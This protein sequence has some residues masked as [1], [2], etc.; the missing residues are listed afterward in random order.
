V[1]ADLAEAELPEA[2]LAEEAELSEAA[3]VEAADLFADVVVEVDRFGDGPAARVALAREGARSGLAA[4]P[5]GSLPDAGRR[6]GPGRGARAGWVGDGWVR[7]LPGDHFWLGERPGS[8]VVVDSRQVD[9]RQVERPPGAP[10]AG[11]WVELGWAVGDWIPL[12]A[13]D[14]FLPAERSGWLLPAKRWGWLVRVDWLP[15]GRVRDDCFRGEPVRDDWRTV[16]RV[17]SEVDSAADSPAG[18]RVRR[19][20][21]R[22]ADC[23][24]RVDSADWLVGPDVRHSAGCRRPE[25]PCWE[26]L[27]FPGEPV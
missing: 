22:S 8:L 20:G 18:C 23:W 9:S 24:E 27:V 21:P 14:H 15:D 3:P 26:W 12:K 6:G 17:D 16:V 1:V 4:R 2:A 25:I 19:G 13:G 11:D 7:L 10:A 5:V